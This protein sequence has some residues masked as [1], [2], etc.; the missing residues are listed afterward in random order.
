VKKK[1]KKITLGFN[2][3]IGGKFCRMLCKITKLPLWV[4]RGFIDLIRV[5][6]IV[7][8]NKF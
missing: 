3:H 5:L 4:F 7:K 2:Q 6:T 1:K 8:L